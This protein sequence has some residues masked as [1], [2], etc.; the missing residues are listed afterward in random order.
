M[1]PCRWNSTNGQPNGKNLQG[2]K[3]K[4]QYLDTFLIPVQWLG[5]TPLAF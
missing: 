2:E 3:F 1:T 5:L 4:F